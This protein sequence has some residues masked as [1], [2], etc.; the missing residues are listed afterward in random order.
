M[1]RDDLNKLKIPDTPGVYF[2]LGPRKE[3]LYIG[4][5]A[6]LRDRVRSYF[7]RD[8]PQMRSQ[9]IVQMVE[10]AHSIDWRETDSVL[11]ALILEASLI[12]TYKPKHN[13]LAKDDKSFNHV[14]ITK[15]DFPRVLVVRGKDLHDG[16]SLRST[17][18]DLRSSFG[19]FPHGTQLKEAMKIVRKIFPYRDKCTPCPAVEVRSPRGGLTSTRRGCRPCFNRQIGLCPGVCTGEIGKREYARIIRHITLFFEGKKKKLLQELERDMKKAAREERFEEAARI[20]KQLFALQHIQDVSLIKDEFRRPDLG[21]KIF[22]IEAYDAAHLHGADAV[23]VMTVVEN[24]EINKREYRTFTL[25]E[26]KPGDDIGALKE[27]LSR[28]LGHS[29]WQLPNLIVVDG[30]KTQ[31][32]AAESVLREA[33]VAIPVV[34]VVKD[35]R[36]KARGL[37]GDK[38]H[39]SQHQ[40]AIILANS[41]AHRFA[42]GTHRRKRKIV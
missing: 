32:A 8:L 31:I 24:N 25:K 5:A 30:G 28:R 42:I 3:V 17:N 22:R 37:M 38:A 35:D 36:H 14:V 41:E 12:K 11:E 21:A 27:V 20:R 6:S 23:G 15:E 7:S 9:L 16:V 2:F 13:T 1:E 19:P 18:Y 10:N 34:S 26:T 4:K 33:G 40:N 29:E 39:A